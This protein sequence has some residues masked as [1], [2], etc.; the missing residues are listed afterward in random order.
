MT[1]PNEQIIEAVQKRHPQNRQL[2]IS[3][4]MPKFFGG[5]L[6]VVEVTENN[7]LVGE[8]Y[9]YINSRNEID[10]TFLNI[11]EFVGWADSDEAPSRPKE[12]WD[13]YAVNVVPGAIAI[14]L[15]LMICILLG[16]QQY[17]NNQFVIPDFLSNALTL[18]LGFYFGQQ[19]SR[20]N[21]GTK[22]QKE[23]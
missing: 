20:S 4:S 11:D 22:E 23:S 2:R 9:A 8:S 7:Q 21:I 6:V 14:I 5:E 19:V 17:R 15:T 18:I 13:W 1:L 12:R 10:A 16:V 3:R